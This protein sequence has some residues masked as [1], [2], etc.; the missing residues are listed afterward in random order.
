MKVYVSA[1][2][3]YEC[4]SQN[5]IFENIER[6]CVTDDTITTLLLNVRSLSKHACDIKSDGRLISNVLS[7]TETQLQHQH[8]LND[9]EHYFENFWIFFNS[10]DNKILSLPYAFHNF[11]RHNLDI[12]SITQEDFCWCVN[13]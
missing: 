6:I 3:E 13:F 11:K 10:N 7:F 5:S 8:S 1:L 9:I 4:V 12:T 2:Q